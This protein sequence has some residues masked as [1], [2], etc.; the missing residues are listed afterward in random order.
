MFNV[1]SGKVLYKLT[2]SYS[3]LVT[4]RGDTFCVF[5]V[6]P[7]K[8]NKIFVTSHL[9]SLITMINCFPWYIFRNS[10]Y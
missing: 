5:C 7:G 1:D 10:K 6:T 3:T 2:P 4:V 8:N 9:S